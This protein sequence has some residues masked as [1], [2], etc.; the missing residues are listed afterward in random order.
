MSYPCCRGPPARRTRA[1]P[2]VTTADAV[3]PRPAPPRWA[4][5]CRLKSDRK[6]TTKFSVIINTTTII[7]LSNVVFVS[8][9]PD[10]VQHWESSSPANT[11]SREQRGGSQR[12]QPCRGREPEIAVTCLRRA[13]ARER[14]SE[15]QPFHSPRPAEVDPERLARQTEG[16]TAL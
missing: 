2:L 16:G 10:R 12:K 6:E 14:S 9:R 3:M 13:A 4:Q 15:H 8:G 5:P 11:W 7:I 1:R